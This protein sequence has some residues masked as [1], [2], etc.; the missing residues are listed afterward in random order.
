MSEAHITF[1]L[2]KIP[3]N[4]FGEPDEFA[5]MVMWARTE[6]YSFCID[7]KFD[8]WGGRATC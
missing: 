7:A 5:A 2:S 3:M 8:L 6:E 4:L 1:M